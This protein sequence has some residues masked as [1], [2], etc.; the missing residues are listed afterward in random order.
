MNKRFTRVIAM[1]LCVMLLL[2]ACQGSEGSGDKKEAKSNTYETPFE[3][4]CKWINNKKAPS[5]YME[6]EI[7]ELNGLCEDEVKELVNIIK[8]SDAY[9]GIL[10]EYKGNFELEVEYYKDRYGDDYKLEYKITD[11]EKL[12]KD[13]LMDIQDEYR[14]RGENIINTVDNMTDGD[15]EY[16]AENMEITVSQAKKFYESMKDIGNELAEI[17]ITEGYYLTVSMKATGSNLDEAD[18]WEATLEVYKVN[19][20]WV[21]EDALWFLADVVY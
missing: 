13:E 1:L 21:T 15:Y 16:K 20:R 17:E 19:G 7:E 9:D 8:K 6:Q 10:A 2:S 18:E 5:S 3:I 11:K 14:Y 12:D 4:M